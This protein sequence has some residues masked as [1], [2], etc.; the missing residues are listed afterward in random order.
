MIDLPEAGQA[1]VYAGLRAPARSDRDYLALELAN[2]ILGGGS[3][4]RLFEEVRTKRSIS[5]GAG[6]G[7][8]ARADDAY[9]IAS[10]QTQNSTAD[11]VVQVF[12]DEFDRLGSE[13]FDADLVDTRRTYLTGGHERSFETSSGFNAIVAELLMNGLE[14]GE[15]ARY[16]D[17]LAAVTPAQ[18]SAT[19][20]NYVSAEKATI[21]VVGKA[22]EFIDDLR[23]I[24]PDVEVI[25]AENIDLS[26][27]DLRERVE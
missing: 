26:R 14:P 17:N 21:I 9:L 10:S 7:L 25:S 8:P 23:K 19:A 24:R 27:A 3:S 22:S 1:A 15:A 5:Y 6:S 13:P 12:L 16:A 11:E 18:A 20:S 4:G 2:S